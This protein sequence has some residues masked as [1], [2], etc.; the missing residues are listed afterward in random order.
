MAVVIIKGKSAKIVHR[1]FMGFHFWAPGYCAGT[2]GLK[3]HQIREYVK[4]QEKIEQ[5]KP[6][7]LKFPVLSNSGPF[8][9]PSAYHALWA[10]V[11]DFK[12]I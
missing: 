3:K 4:N 1:E 8:R 9:G 7:Q 5:G 12:Q 11:F 10:C 2:I 6:S